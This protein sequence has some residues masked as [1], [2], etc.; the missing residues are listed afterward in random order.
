MH[1]IFNGMV[2]CGY[3]EGPGNLIL[4]PNSIFV[5]KNGEKPDMWTS[6]YGGVVG[7]MLRVFINQKMMEDTPPAFLDDPELAGLSK[8]ERR[9]LLT[10][11]VLAK[12]DRRGPAFS[13]TPTP[14]GFAF[15]DGLTGARYSG[16]LSKKK[17]SRFLGYP[18]PLVTA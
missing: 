7:A 2:A 14:M 5:L 11:E 10:A 13:A 1:L 3:D 6:L 15:N 8:K 18:L 16:W 17:I 9:A 4:T 12:Y